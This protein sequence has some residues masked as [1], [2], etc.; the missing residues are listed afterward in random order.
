MSAP[1][2]GLLR[3]QTS[4]VITYAAVRLSEVTS[5]LGDAAIAQNERAFRRSMLVRQELHIVAR[6]QE[7]FTDAETTPV[8]GDDI[9][10]D[11]DAQLALVNLNDGISMCPPRWNG[12]PIP[13][14]TPL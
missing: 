8:L 6:I 1:C 10:I 11:D 14:K 9:S 7:P 12:I 5:D 4:R 13:L 3:P 2:G